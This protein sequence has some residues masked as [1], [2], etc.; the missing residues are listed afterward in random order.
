MAADD[1]TSMLVVVVVVALSWRI[2]AMQNSKPA[3][4]STMPIGN[5]MIITPDMTKPVRFNA[6]EN[7]Y[8][9]YC[10]D[11]K[12]NPAGKRIAL[13]P[14]AANEKLK[15]FY[16]DRAEAEHQAAHLM[17]V[18]GTDE[19]KTRPTDRQFGRPGTDDPN[20]CMMAT[21][22]RKHSGYG[23][24]RFIVPGMQCRDC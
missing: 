1:L 6:A 22:Q 10:S 19:A 14:T 5:A 23:Q 3:L 15:S 12:G 9:P 20:V 21:Y 11:T 2:M 4:M 17:P 7:C 16:Q 13:I 8:D 24:D 18:W